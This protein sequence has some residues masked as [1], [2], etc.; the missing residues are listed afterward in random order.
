[1][2]NK[3]GDSVAMRKNAQVLWIEDDDAFLRAHRKALQTENILVE[4][5]RTGSD[6]V[7]KL[8]EEGQSKRDE[9][10]KSYPDET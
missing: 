4:Q 9:Q 10:G 3:L 8:Q 2:E 6:A 1:M 7:R 5:I